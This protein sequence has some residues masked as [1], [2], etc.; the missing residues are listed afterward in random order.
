M[1]DV[2]GPGNTTCERYCQRRLQATP[3]QQTNSEGGHAGLADLAA[4]VAATALL[5]VPTA[6]WFHAQSAP[7][8]AFLRVL[9]L[10]SAHPAP[11]ATFS[12]SPNTLRGLRATA[13]TTALSHTSRLHLF[14]L[15]IEFGGGQSSP[16][17]RST[18]IPVFNRIVSLRT[19]RVPAIVHAVTSPSVYDQTPC[20]Y[21]RHPPIIQ[22]PL[23]KAQSADLLG[24]AS[25]TPCHDYSFILDAC[26]PLPLPQLS[27]E[28]IQPRRKSV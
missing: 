10:L 1:C 3:K 14:A 19:L 25:S 2:S 28:A 23:S 11:T 13:A 8:A 26:I 18:D 5:R 4:A 20:P 24:V 15:R 9:A 21:H 17:G 16:H 12:P 6:A 22:V 7:A 27:T